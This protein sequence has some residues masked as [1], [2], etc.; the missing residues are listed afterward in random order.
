[1]FFSLFI[2]LGNSSKISHPQFGHLLPR[3]IFPHLGHVF[4]ISPIFITL[5]EFESIF[6]KCI[7]S[8]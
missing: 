4:P 1:M 5:I 7:H 8:K 3:K 6:N 2:D